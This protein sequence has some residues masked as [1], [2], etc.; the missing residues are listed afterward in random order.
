MTV[1]PSFTEFVDLATQG[2]I[3]PVYAEILADMETP[4]SAF[5]KIDRGSWSYLLESVEGG[6]K[7]GR[8]SIIGLPARERLRVS[9]HQVVHESDDGIIME[10]TDS[11]AEESPTPSPSAEPT[12]SGEPDATP[13]GMESIDDVDAPSADATESTAEPESMWGASDADGDGEPET[14]DTPLDGVADRA[15]ADPA[16]SGQAT[17]GTSEEAVRGRSDSAFQFES[18]E[19]GEE[20]AGTGGGSRRGPA[21]IASEG[22]IDLDSE[23]ET[24]Y[25]TLVCPDCGFSESATTSLRAGDICPECHRG[26]LAGRR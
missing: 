18:H 2:N 19:P 1:Y 6:E 21:G 10:E 23:A 14:A 15:S 4:V 22:P 24:P 16:D 7:W 11:T 5:K 17:T 9:G 20:G 26:Y 12:E 3:V 13:G 8:Y 25:R